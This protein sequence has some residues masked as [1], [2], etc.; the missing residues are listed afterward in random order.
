MTLREIPRRRLATLAVVTLSAVVVAA[1]FAAPGDRDTDRETRAKN[2]LFSE[3]FSFKA[4]GQLVV[5]V[6]DMDIRIET[7][8]GTGG[9]VE[10]YGRGSNRERVQEYFEKLSFEARMDGN[11]LII[12]SDQPHY[13]HH[14]FWRYV[15]GVHLL[16]VITVPERTDLDIDTEDGDVRLDKV[17]GRAR[18]H[19]ED[20]DLE[21]SEI[22]GPSIDVETEDGDVRAELLE[23]DEITL[24]TEDGDVQVGR[25]KGS[26]VRVTS[27][28]GDI[29]L[30]Q[31]DADDVSIDADDGDIEITV[32]AKKLTA[33]C[34]DGD[35]VVTLLKEM[36]VDLRTDDGD[37]EINIPKNIGA[38][39]D[40]RGGHV[41]VRSKI[42]IKGDISRR[43]IRGEIN[44]GGPAI[45][46]KSDDGTILVREG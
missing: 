36:K 8:S 41:S 12:Q 3:E 31:I 32:A 35:L 33:E 4:G 13:E 5:D 9:S 22:R 34:S 15:R 18:I 2:K 39:L 45:R 20:G 28:D 10:V 23:G 6:D 14:S 1:A 29:E 40:L 11:K 46:A 44:D 30:R 26:R 7:G 16:A 27:S 17:S 25:I 24:M 38:D 21:L 42:A 43:S 37:I 19:T